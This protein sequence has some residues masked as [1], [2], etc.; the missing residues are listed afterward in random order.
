MLCDISTGRHRP[1]V[2]VKL[3]RTVFDVVYGL[4]LPSIKSTVKLIKSTFVSHSMEKEIR[5]WAKIC[6]AC[7]CSKTQR[8]IKTPIAKYPQPTRRFAH[9]YIDIVVSSSTFLGLPLLTHHHRSSYHEFPD[10][11]YTNISHVI[12]VVPLFPDSGPT[13]LIYSVFSYITPRP[14]THNQIVWFNDG[15]VDLN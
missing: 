3:H 7:Q 15:T 1:L 2:P 5:L 9:I 4:A 11:S 8:H 14:I 10:L 6:H 12:E 13:S